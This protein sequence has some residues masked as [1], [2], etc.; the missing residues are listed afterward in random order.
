VSASTRGKHLR[1]LNACLAAAVA[2]G[3]A[4]TNPVG[5][6]PKAQR[7]RPGKREAAYFETAELAPVF[8]A[9]T[10]GVYRTI[11]E[12]ALKTGA[13]QGELIAATWGDVDLAEAV[14]RIR[15]TRTDGHVHEPK[16]HE[17]RDVDLT[18]DVV[19]LLGW[20]W[21]ARAAARNDGRL[22]RRDA[23]RL[24]RRLSALSRMP[25]RPA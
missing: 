2:H 9:L 17:R 16:S 21:R 6:L 14:L 22:P 23:E 7:P 12:V 20:W 24:P 5:Q 18:P 8:G 3:Y 15:R 25:S 1:V 19:E 11:C 4:A 13:R 10:P